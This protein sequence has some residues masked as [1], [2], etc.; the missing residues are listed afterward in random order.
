MCKDRWGLGLCI[1]L[2]LSNMFLIGIILE[3][4]VLLGESELCRKSLLCL[5]HIV[6]HV[7]D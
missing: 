6:I 7:C 2:R 5:L 1:S 3:V 4:K